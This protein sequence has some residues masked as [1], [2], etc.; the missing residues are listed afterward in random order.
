MLVEWEELSE[1]IYA[2]DR[3][4]VAE[5]QQCEVY[6]RLLEV[7]GIGTQTAMALAAAEVWWMGRPSRR[8]A[9]WRLGTG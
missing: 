8:G 9:T 5:A 3:E 1:R 7:P 6:R 2:I 4:L